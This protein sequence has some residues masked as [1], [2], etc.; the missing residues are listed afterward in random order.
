MLSMDQVLIVKV[1]IA[2]PIRNARL[3]PTGLTR[4]TPYNPSTLSPE[5]W[6]LTP[7]QIRNA[8]SKP[9]TPRP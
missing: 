9:S 7:W 1:D 2:R 5:P 6:R 8:L 3:F 4:L